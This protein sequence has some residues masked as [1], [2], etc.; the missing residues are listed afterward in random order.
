MKSALILLPFAALA[1]SKPMPHNLG[2]EARQQ[3]AEGTPLF[4]NSPFCN[5]FQCAVTWKA[6]DQAVVNWLNAPDGD[7]QVDLSELSIAF[8]SV[9]R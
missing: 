2:L 4:L 7:V 3:Q 1:T 5:F 6:G 8:L 9:L